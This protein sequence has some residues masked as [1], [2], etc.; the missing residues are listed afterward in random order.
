[1]NHVVK[2]VVAAEVASIHVSLQ[3]NYAR[4]C[5][6]IPVAG[7]TWIIAVMSRGIEF[8]R[9]CPAAAQYQL[10]HLH[11]RSGSRKRSLT[12]RTFGLPSFPLSASCF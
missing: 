1:M 12:I 10:R 11:R 6:T 3:Q 7:S 8:V 4:R 9:P 5:V 2:R